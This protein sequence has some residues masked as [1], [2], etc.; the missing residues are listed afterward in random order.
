MITMN[1]RIE[2][3]TYS[4]YEF[5]DKLGEI[6]LRVPILKCFLFQVTLI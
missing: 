6:V 1:L 4:F 3:K 5:E 2:K